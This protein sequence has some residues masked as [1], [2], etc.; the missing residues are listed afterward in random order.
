[1]GAARV[2]PPA[3]AVR[4]VGRLSGR[5]TSD[6]GSSAELLA[7]GANALEQTVDVAQRRGHR[8]ALRVVGVAFTLMFPHSMNTQKRDGLLGWLRWLAAAAPP[9][10]GGAL[11]LSSAS[12][13]LAAAASSAA[14]SAAASSS[15]WSLPADESACRV[16][17]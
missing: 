16:A 5:R 10:G 13:R 1:M 3:R 9:L 12:S 2:S 8:D 4:H 6:A 7:A 11:A 15:K 14:F 17:M